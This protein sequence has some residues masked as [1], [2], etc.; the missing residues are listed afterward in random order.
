[1]KTIPLKKNKPNPSTKLDVA[2]RMMRYDKMSFN[3]SFLTNDKQFNLDTLQP[4]N[5][6]K[7]LNKLQ[8]LSAHNITKVKLLPREQGIEFIESL[9]KS[10]TITEFRSSGRFDECDNNYCVFRISN[11]GRVIGKLNNNL[12][13]VLAIDTKFSLYDH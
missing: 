10:I 4:V 8:L 7:L 5:H 9:K 1:M 6:K 11:N 3:F 12:F 2:K 13:Y